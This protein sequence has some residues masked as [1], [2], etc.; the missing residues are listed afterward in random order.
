MLELGAGE[1]LGLASSSLFLARRTSS[2]TGLGQGPPGARDRCPQATPLPSSQ[3]RV[4]SPSKCPGV[5]WRR[6]S[7]CLV[8]LAP[9]WCVEGCSS[10]HVLSEGPLPTS[11][12]NQAW[13][14]LFFNL[15]LEDT[16]VG[17]GVSGSGGPVLGERPG[18][19]G[20][21]RAGPQGLWEGRARPPQPSICWAV[22]TS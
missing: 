22:P 18:E 6:P 20:G 16:Q 1:G 19:V 4:R 8:S 10:L 11:T 13:C 14:S 5:A 17:N 7:P 9:W 3:R 12:L 21:V 2:R 15:G